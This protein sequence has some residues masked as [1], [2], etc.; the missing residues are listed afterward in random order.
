MGEIWVKS[1]SRS[2]GYWRDEVKTEADFNG[3]IASKNEKGYLRT[4]DLGFLHKSDSR[5]KDKT[6]RKK[7]ETF[8]MKRTS[9]SSSCLLF[10]VGVASR[11]PSLS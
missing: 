7:E 1:P 9:S 10:F 5:K 4:G 3:S 6:T 2:R 8:S 11:P